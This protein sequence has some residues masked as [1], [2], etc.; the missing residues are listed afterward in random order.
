MDQQI[1]EKCLDMAHHHMQV[2]V[3][4]P[5]YAKIENVRIFKDRADSGSWHKHG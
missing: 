5:D 2:M 4:G 1:I 3:L